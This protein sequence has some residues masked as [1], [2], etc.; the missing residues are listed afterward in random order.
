MPV[1]WGSH[2]PLELTWFA[3]D[4]I[5]D[6]TSSCREFQCQLPRKM[7]NFVVIFLCV[8]SVLRGSVRCTSGVANWVGLGS[9]RQRRLAVERLCLGALQP[10]GSGFRLARGQVHPENLGNEIVA[11]FFWE[12]ILEAEVVDR[13][14]SKHRA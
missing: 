9:P 8:S 3:H 7:L 2:R 5:C 6:A 11:F 13:S 10:G 14:R 12:L 4:A 1:A